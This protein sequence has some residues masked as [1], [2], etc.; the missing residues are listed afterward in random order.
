MSEVQEKKENIEV[1]NEPWKSYNRQELCDLHEYMRDNGMCDAFEASSDVKIAVGLVN[2][3]DRL[4][5]I[6]VGIFLLNKTMSKL[7]EKLDLS[8]KK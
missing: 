7:S 2:I 8:E 3:A 4:E 1:D 5:K 6:G